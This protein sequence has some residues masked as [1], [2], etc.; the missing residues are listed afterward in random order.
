MRWGDQ[1]L[2]IPE[3]V[4]ACRWLTAYPPPL[5]DDSGNVGKMMLKNSWQFMADEQN[6]SLMSPERDSLFDVDNTRR[7][8]LGIVLFFIF[9]SFLRIVWFRSF[10]HFCDYTFEEFCRLDRWNSFSLIFTV[11]L[12]VMVLVSE[13]NL[14]WSF[15]SH[16]K[17]CKKFLLIVID[18]YRFE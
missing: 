2:K 1:P 10:Y 8:S 16:S 17:V 11:V 6:A 18:K 3:S 14:L 5:L 15:W 7:S 12:H 4:P 9:Y 13:Y